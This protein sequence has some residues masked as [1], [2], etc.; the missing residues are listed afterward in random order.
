MNLVHRNLQLVTQNV[1]C[2]GRCVRIDGLHEILLIAGTVSI[3]AVGFGGLVATVNMNWCPTVTAS[4]FTSRSFS[5][6]GNKCCVAAST[7]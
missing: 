5:K 7:V 1:W 2:A 3:D 6:L 4:F